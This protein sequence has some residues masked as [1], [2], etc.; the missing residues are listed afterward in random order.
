MKLE[1]FRYLIE[2]NRQ[3]SISSAAKNLYMGQTTL[4]AVVKSVENELGFVIFQRTSKG[5]Y[6]TAAGNELLCIAEE[7]LVKYD[8]ILQLK[9]KSSGI[10][11]PATVL[12]STTFSV[13]LPVSLS[14]R[15]HAVSPNSSLILDSCPR[16]QVISRLIDNEANI[17][18]THIHPEEQPSLS[19]QLKK[20]GLLLES[21]RSDSFYLCVGRDHPL[22][23][24]STVTPSSLPPVTVASVKDFYKVGE[25]ES[26]FSHYDRQKLS[27]TVFPNIES[28][29]R[30]VRH[31]NMVALFTGYLVAT[32]LNPKEFAA[33]PVT[34]MDNMNQ[35][36]I[37][38]IRR[39]NKNLNYLEKLLV[40]NIRDYFNALELPSLL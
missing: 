18:I 24:I 36:D 29:C 15:I 14:E 17:G 20:N 22:A 23:N 16:F 11:Y 30:A 34:E 31:Q 35:I 25:V 32:Q 38:M 33:I 10:S 6:P 13:A 40:E 3:H 9:D 39:H 7:I 4:S 28:A 8:E 37:C 19:N 5:V 12:F 1:Y 26:L 27:Y 2:I 21:L